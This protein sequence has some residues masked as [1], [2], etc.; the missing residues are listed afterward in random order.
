MRA[1]DRL[2]KYR[3][4]LNLLAR[5]NVSRRLQAKL[6]LSGVVQQTLFEA[7]QSPKPS[8]P[9]NHAQWEAWLR[10]ILARNLTDAIRR[11]TADKRDVAREQSLDEDAS[12]TSARLEAW[13][14]APE[15][16]PSEQAVRQEQWL[17][18][19]EALA[20]LPI[21]QQRAIELHHLQG[22]SLAATAEALNRSR[23]AVAGLL[24]RGLARLR[25]L[26]DDKERTDD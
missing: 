6:D 14:A 11:L 22:S 19:S 21:D 24:H 12:Q 3:E 15:P 4:Y 16:S 1:E 10:R 5:V 2:E 17:A 20:Q 13:L 8:Q 25:K 18:L 23:P 9:G 26:L 7:H